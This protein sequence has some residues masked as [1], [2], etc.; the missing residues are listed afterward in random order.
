[1]TLVVI[2]AHSKAR[3]TLLRHWNHYERARSPFCVVQPENVGVLAPVPPG[4]GNFIGTLQVGREPYT[5]GQNHALTFL[6]T[7]QLLLDGQ[8]HAGNWDQLCLTEYDSLF[9]GPVPTLV[10][11]GIMTTLAGHLNGDFRGSRFFHA[12]WVLQRNTAEFVVERGLRMLKADLSE[13]GYID[14]FLGLLM[15]LYPEV[16]HI[17]SGCYSHNTIDL[18]ELVAEARLAIQN[19]S[20]HAHGIKT[21]SVFDALIA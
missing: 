17:P 13:H 11:P 8:T 18:P 21:Q 12:P 16:P 20:W 5:N 7:L 10:G 14:R 15:D 3:E 2:F 6:A 19:G 1:M 4:H 9:F